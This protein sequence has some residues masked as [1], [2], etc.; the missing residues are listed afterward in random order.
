MGEHIGL[1]PELRG[2]QYVARAISS[3]TAVQKLD[4]ALRK[5]QG[6]E[7]FDELMVAASLGDAVSKEAD[8][9]S[10]FKRADL[11]APGRCLGQHQKKPNQNL[12]TAEVA[13]K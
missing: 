4:R 13:K 1:N 10:R 8:P 2:R 11:L 12:N 6:V 9:V 7:E 3:N 5:A